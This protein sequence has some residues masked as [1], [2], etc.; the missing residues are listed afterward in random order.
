MPAAPLPGP[1]LP[2]GPKAGW[3]WCDALVPVA[4][5]AVLDAGWELAAA[6]EVELLYEGLEVAG[7]VEMTGATVAG[8]VETAGVTVV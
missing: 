7:D 8:G 6:A 5:A 3:L 4:A 2:P 1:K